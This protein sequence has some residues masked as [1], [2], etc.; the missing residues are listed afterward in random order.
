MDGNEKKNKFG[1]NDSTE[2]PYNLLIR[3]KDY[4][5]NKPR[6]V[7]SNI[8]LH[9][10][11][12]K[13]LR[14]SVKGKSKRKIGIDW[15]T[16]TITNYY[17]MRER[18]YSKYSSKTYFDFDRG[19]HLVIKLHYI[20][21]ANLYCITL[22]HSRSYRLVSCNNYGHPVLLWFPAIPHSPLTSPYMK[23]LFYLLSPSISLSLYPSIIP[24]LLQRTVRRNTSRGQLY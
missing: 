24:H 2:S 16:H 15:G 20:I 22:L 23:L 21:G 17:Q 11:T 1:S 9:F 6:I 7:Y 12:F 13:C 10:F 8:V 14:P 18:H 3:E 5:F 4:V 19:D